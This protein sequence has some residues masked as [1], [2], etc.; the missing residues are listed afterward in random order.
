MLEGHADDAP[1]SAVAYQRRGFL[2]ASGG[3]DGRVNLWQPAVKK[4][5]LVG[6]DDGDS[7]VSVLAWSPDDKALA[8][9]F[10][11]GAVVIYRAG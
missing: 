9:G 11:S 7:E 3:R 10:G 2:L 6:Q 5:P 4:G 8:A 1:V